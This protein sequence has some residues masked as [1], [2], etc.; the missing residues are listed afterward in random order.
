MK[1]VIGIIFIILCV[2]INTKNQSQRSTELYQDDSTMVEFRR[3]DNCE[4]LKM[5]RIN[6]SL[7]NFY[8]NK[9]IPTFEELTKIESCAK[10]GRYG[11]FYKN[12]SQ[13]LSDIRRWK[14]ALGCRS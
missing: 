10:K 14:R 7:S 6:Y 11:Y 2:G 9:M 13:F 12:R 4:K 1:L 5:L 8:I 3:A